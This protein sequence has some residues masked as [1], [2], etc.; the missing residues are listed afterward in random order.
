MA[1]ALLLA[2]CSP[3]AGHDLHG[4]GRLDLGVEADGEA[5]AADRLDGG[6][7]VDAAPVDGGAAGALDRVGDL[8]GRDRPEQAALLAGL[9]RDHHLERLQVA[10]DGAGL[11]QVGDLAL[12][13]PGPDPLRLADRAGGGQAGQ[14]AGQQV[15]AAVA[16]RDVDDV[17]GRPDPPDL[18]IQDDLHWALLSNGVREQGHLP[19]VLD[20]GGDVALVLGA[21]AGDPAGADLAPVAHELAQQV[22]VLVVDVVLVLGAE[23]AE[24]ALGLALEGALGHA[25][26]AFRVPA[27]LLE[28]RLVVELTTLARPGRAARPVATAAATTTRAAPA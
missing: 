1:I 15:V 22:D 5:V 6:V 9:G 20:G 26:A 27:V 18:L 16:G 4:D 12:D 13:P 11:L 17:P 24:L 21:V 10:G 7:Q 25:G 23:L 14:V 28:R 2:H 3:L 19:G 8:R